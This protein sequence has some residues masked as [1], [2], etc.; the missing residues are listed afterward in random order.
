MQQGEAQKLYSH[1]MDTSDLGLTLRCCGPR[2]LPDPRGFREPMSSKPM[3]QAKRQAHGGETLILSAMGRVE[4]R[5]PGEGRGKTHGGMGNPSCAEAQ[6]LHWKES[7]LRRSV[8]VSFPFLCLLHLSLSRS[9]C[10]WCVVD[11]G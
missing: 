3:E 11:D 1:L 7:V 6:C 8:S 2:T 5:V 4:S 10:N 9:P